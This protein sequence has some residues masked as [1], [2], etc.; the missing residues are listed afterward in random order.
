MNCVLRETL[1][2]NK[3]NQNMTLNQALDLLQEQGFLNMGEITE[4]AIS[5]KSGVDLCEPMTPNVDTMT[6][7]QIKFATVKRSARSNYYKA[8]ISRNTTAPI[9]CV[10]N[11]PVL[12]TQYFLHIPYRAHAYLDGSCICVF[13]GSDGTQEESPWLK[14]KVGSWEALCELAKIPS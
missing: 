10:I 13:F 3:L 4:H 11:N 5:K 14:H 6:G 8:Y 1:W 7:K 2:G 9:L 12:N